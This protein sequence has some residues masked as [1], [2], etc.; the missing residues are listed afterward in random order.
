MAKDI[1]VVG[2]G[3]SVDP[4]PEG[5]I[6]RWVLSPGDA[7]HGGTSIVVQEFS[8]S[9]SNPPDSKTKSILVP[10]FDTQISIL[11]AQTSSIELIYK[12]SQPDVQVGVHFGL[13]ARGAEGGGVLNRVA[14]KLLRE[15]LLQALHPEFQTEE[16]LVNDNCTFS[17][18]TNEA[19]VCLVTLDN[20]DP[21]AGPEAALAIGLTRPRRLYTVET[22][23]DDW[24][25]LTL[26]LS[27]LL[28]PLV[29]E[30][31]FSLVLSQLG[32]TLSYPRQNAPNPSQ[33][34]ESRPLVV[35]GSLAVVPTLS[36]EYKGSC[37]QEVRS[38]DTLSW[39]KESRQ[40]QP[41]LPDSV[42]IS[43]TITWDIGSSIRLVSN[44][45]SN[46]PNASDIS[47]SEYSH[48]CIYVS[49]E[50]AGYKKEQDIS[51]D[52][53]FIGT[54]FTR[55]YRIANFKV[56]LDHEPTFGFA[57]EPSPKEVLSS[58]TL[59]RQGY[60]IWVWVQGIRRD[61]RAD[62]RRDWGRSRLL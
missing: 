9:P 56:G 37:V 17:T 54:A 21:A 39:R 36:M 10:L 34:E 49:R 45:P 26:H 55:R 24:Q 8:E 40:Q 44:L 23:P 61:G 5:T 46:P 18:S 47:P 60:E 29:T 33:S 11:N 22:L 19:L 43:S 51:P 62:E 41:D 38:Q 12:P 7:Y 48:F 4:V 16:Y 59:Q 30:N 35:L 25:R 2:R 1:F 32:I 14:R 6:I 42:W 28:N 50:R 57:K 52:N 27:G 31:G 20:P 58:E 3:Y 53:M 15:E 13:L